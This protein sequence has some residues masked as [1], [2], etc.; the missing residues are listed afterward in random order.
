MPKYVI[1]RQYIG[2]YYSDTFKPSSYTGDD[3]QTLVDR[4]IDSIQE[5]YMVEKHGDEYTVI[6][7]ITHTLTGIVTSRFS[8]IFKVIEYE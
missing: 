7:L 3:K 2:N 8:H 5:P 4:Y 1:V 6:E